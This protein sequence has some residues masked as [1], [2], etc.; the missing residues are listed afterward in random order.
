MTI[1][2][3]VK[4]YKYQPLDKKLSKQQRAEYVAALPSTLNLDGDSDCILYYHGIKVSEGYSRIVVGDYGAY[5]EIPP[6]MMELS[7]ICI[8]PG[9][10]YRLKQQYI[11]V[12]YHW[13]CLRN[14][15]D[16]KIYHQQ[17]PVTYA[18]YTPGMFYVAPDG[19]MVLKTCGQT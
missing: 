5:I 6:E 10:E 3:L 1:S 18:D 13:Y 12:K 15:T 4:K 9:E 19:I 7:N 11:N 14:D 2:E 16:F 8:K 17:H